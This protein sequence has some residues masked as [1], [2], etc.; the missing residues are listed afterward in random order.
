[1]LL[2]SI[3][4]LGTLLIGFSKSATG[5]LNLIKMYFISKGDSLLAADGTTELYKNMTTTTDIVI[6]SVS[7][8]DS[9]HARVDLKLQG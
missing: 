2:Q 4:L 3:L 5:T 6:A 1:M 8:V 9:V 7:H